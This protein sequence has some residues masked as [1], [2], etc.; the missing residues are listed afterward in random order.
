V[1]VFDLSDDDNDECWRNISSHF[2]CDDGLHLSGT[3]NWVTLSKDLSAVGGSLKPSTPHINFFHIVSLD[4]STETYTQL[5]LPKGF[6]EVPCAEP[7]LR[8][9]LDCLCF[10]HDFRKTEFVLWQMKEFGVQE[11]WTQLFRIRYVD[12]QMRNLPIDVQYLD[13]SPLVPLYIS[14]SRDTVILTNE[15]D[16][17]AII[18]SQRDTRAD[19]ARISNKIHWF[20][21]IDYVESLVPT[22]WK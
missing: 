9:L 5:L 11:S 17:A 1:R 19:R 14:K 12:L 4:L 7:N 10:S 20:S 3:I 22:P 16:E 8:V 21:A 6:D 13:E 18:Y 15:E 2:I